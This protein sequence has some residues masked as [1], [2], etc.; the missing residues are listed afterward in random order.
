MSFE[1]I[2]VTTVPS[3]VGSV[4][5]GKST[6]PDAILGTGLTSKLQQI[7]Y[8]VREQS[9]LPDG[10]ASWKSASMN[11]HGV[12]REQENVTVLQY[13]RSAID[14]GLRCQ[15]PDIPFQLILGGECCMLPAILSAFWENHG[16]ANK[17]VGLFYIDADCDLEFPGEPG[18]LGNLASMTMTHLTMRPGALESMKDFTREDGAG[19]IDSSNVVL[20]GLN[21]ASNTS[22]KRDHLAYLFNEGFRVITSTAVA[23]DPVGR[24]KQALRWLEDNSVDEILVHFD[25]DSIDA[26]DFPL[27]NVP[28]YS[29]ATFEKV[30]AAIKTCLNNKK[31]TGLVV[32][33][34][35]PDHDPGSIMMQR[36]T[37]ALVE[38]FESRAK[39]YLA[40]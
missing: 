21:I 4:I 19:V 13:V 17:K 14:E 12:K 40:N 23:S 16:R 10:P 1:S 35:N 3:D 2:I 36:L 38:G 26:G 11:E 27:A 15:A 24:A 30:L 7:G 22:A 37:D 33:E 32:A 8:H 39:T 29:G 31:V 5:R 6:A 9:A 20:F 28:N 18:S 34:V 25:V